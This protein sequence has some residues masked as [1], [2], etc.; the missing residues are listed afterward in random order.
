MVYLTRK[1]R[2]SLHKKWK[3]NDQGLSYKA[4]RRGAQQFMDGSIAIRWCGMW[5]GIETDGYTHS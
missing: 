3:Q 1:Q 2:E 5:L 4:F